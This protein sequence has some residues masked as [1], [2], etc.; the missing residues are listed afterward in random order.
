MKR[1]LSVTGSGTKVPTT[2]LVSFPGAYTASTPVRSTFYY[3]PPILMN[4]YFP[5]VLFSIYTLRSR[6]ILF[7]DR[8][9]ESCPAQSNI[10]SDIALTRWTG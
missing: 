8:L 2:N 3:P 5:R 1:I 6:A 4:V 9:S 7:L 10:I